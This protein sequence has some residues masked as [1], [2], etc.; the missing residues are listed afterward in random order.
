MT[1]LLLS[2]TVA[3][4]SATHLR[5]ARLGLRRKVTATGLIAL[6]DLPAGTARLAFYTRSAYFSQAEIERQP[7]KLLPIQARRLIDAELAFNEPFR[8]R[9][10]AT[11]LPGQ[12]RQNLT[13]AAVAEADYALLASRLPLSTRPFASITPAECAMAALLG[14]LTREPVR[15][16]WRRGSQMLGLLVRQGAIHARHAARSEQDVA[17]DEAAFAERVLPLLG[18]AATRFAGGNGAAAVLPALAL[19]EW[20]SLPAGFDSTV[21]AGLRVQLQRLFA[22]APVDDVA[23]WPELYGLRFVTNHF[24]FLTSDYQAEAQGVFLARPLLRMSA[25]ATAVIGGLAVL[26][27][28]QANQLGQGMEKRRTTLET[29]HKA[30]EGQRPAPEDLEKLKRRL[31]VQSTLEGLRLDRF[32]AW[33]SASTPA[34]VIIRKLEVTRSTAAAAPPVAAPPIAQSVAAKEPAASMQS[35]SA[36]IEFEVPGSYAQAEQKSAAIMAALG[37]K[38]KLMSS[39]LRVDNDQSARLSIALAAQ[40][41]AFL[42]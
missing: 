16:L 25:V 20:G 41:N 4:N 17:L 40:E 37:S 26:A 28:V 6:A 13:L 18:S 3:A 7:A 30:V 11:A 14:K 36:A 42:E 10:N 34:G 35:W 12:G 19:G 31:G 2:A 38:G 23:Q 1:M 39:A 27:A 21:G 9:H 33:I 29:Q 15:L 24:N 32:L 22:G 8:A 5:F